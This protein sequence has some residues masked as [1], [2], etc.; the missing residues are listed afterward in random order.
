[1]FFLSQIT[2]RAPSA[3][4]APASSACVGACTSGPAAHAPSSPAGCRS[5]TQAAAAGQ[6][7]SERE[8]GEDL[9]GAS[10]CAQKLPQSPGPRTQLCF[11]HGLPR[12]DQHPTP[13]WPTLAPTMS[14]PGPPGAFLIEVTYSMVIISLLSGIALME[15]ALQCP[16]ALFTALEPLSGSH[17]LYGCLPGLALA[18][19]EGMARAGLCGNAGWL[20]G[21]AV[22]L[23]GCLP[24]HR[25]S[26][27]KPM[28]ELYTMFPTTHNGGPL[29]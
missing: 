25:E 12:P 16:R 4:E 7:P 23:E 11:G 2:A 10:L 13:S 19:R 27:P 24:E 15:P 3:A 9:A 28:N 21:M 26:I 8:P 1:M 18:H 20:S 29:R 5:G 17:S 22:T 6:A 14:S